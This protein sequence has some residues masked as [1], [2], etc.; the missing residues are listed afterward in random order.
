MQSPGS[1]ALALGVQAPDRRD[2]LFLDLSAQ[3]G[4][5]TCASFEAEDVLTERCLSGR[6]ASGM[7]SV[8]TISGGR[9][10]SH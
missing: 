6:V 8:G 10:D 2:L 1:H 7:R 3:V 9:C 5:L 4:S